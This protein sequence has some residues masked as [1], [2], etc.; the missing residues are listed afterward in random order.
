MYDDFG[1]W[2]EEKYALVEPSLWQDES[3]KYISL[4]HQ[5]ALG[6]NGISLND[7]YGEETG[8]PEDVNADGRV[9]VIDLAAAKKMCAEGT[10]TVSEIVRLAKYLVNQN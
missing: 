4:D 8:L 5:I 2:D 10:Y 6:A 9:N 7:Y 3:G 1:K